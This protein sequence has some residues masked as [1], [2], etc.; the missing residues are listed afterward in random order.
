V[1]IQARFEAEPE[2]PRPTVLLPEPLDVDVA[3]YAGR[4]ARVQVDGRWRAVDAACGPERLDGDWWRPGQAFARDYWV[5]RVG[6]R[7][8]WVFVEGGVWKLHGW[9]D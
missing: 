4:P 5:L 6:D 7:T 9:F 2:R 3:Q 1:A 8:A